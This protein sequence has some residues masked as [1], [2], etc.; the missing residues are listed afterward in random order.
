MTIAPREGAA[1]RRSPHHPNRCRHPRVLTRIPLE[2]QRTLPRTLHWFY[3]TSRLDQC[4][5]QQKNIRLAAAP[6]LDPGPLSFPLNWPWPGSVPD[7]APQSGFRGGGGRYGRSGGAHC[8]RPV[9]AAAAAAAAAARMIALCRASVFKSCGQC[10]QQQG[11]GNNSRLPLCSGCLEHV[12]LLHL[13]FKKGSSLRLVGDRRYQKHQK[14]GRN[15]KPNAECRSCGPCLRRVAKSAKTSRSQPP[16]LQL[17]NTND[18]VAIPLDFPRARMRRQLSKQQVLW[19]LPAHVVRIQ[20][21]W[22][23]KAR[24][25]AHKQRGHLRPRATVARLRLQRRN[26]KAS[27]KTSKEL[28]GMVAT[29]DCKL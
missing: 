4:K 2:R 24:E 18:G 9:S 3:A 11:Q 14:H 16:Q 26:Q 29:A 25:V 13:A 7:K 19:L 21:A 22:F 20:A 23:E 5:S 10:T 28:L 6:Y 17:P 12:P 15:A 1:D 8:S 27:L